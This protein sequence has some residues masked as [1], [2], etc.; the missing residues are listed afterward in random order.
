MKKTPTSG[1][2]P[3]VCVALVRLSK[4]VVF[5]PLQNQ[6]NLDSR[7]ILALHLYHLQ[8]QDLLSMSYSN[9]S[10]NDL[11]A[12]LDQCPQRLFRGGCTLR[13][14]AQV[15]HQALLLRPLDPKDGWLRPCQMSNQTNWMWRGM[16]LDVRC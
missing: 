1:G 9:P 10:T 3:I 8:I 11:H 2:A 16:V 12:K 7:S 14:L 13:N 5:T 15:V 4:T 6:A